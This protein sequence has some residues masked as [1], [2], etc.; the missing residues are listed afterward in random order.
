MEDERGVRVRKVQAACDVGHRPPAR[1]SENSLR[2]R[3]PRRRRRCGAWR[4]NHHQPAALPAALFVRRSVEIRAVLA[5]RG[6]TDR[7]RAIRSDCRC[8]GALRALAGAGRRRRRVNTRR[9]LHGLRLWRGYDGRPHRVHGSANRTKRCG[10]HT[11]GRLC[12]TRRD[13]CRHARSRSDRLGSRRG[14]RR[15]EQRRCRVLRRT[16]RRRRLRICGPRRARGSEQR[17]DHRARGGRHG[18]TVTLGGV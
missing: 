12:R 15:R 17:D 4:K 8:H 6:G 18:I 16:R 13:L 9:L 14:G 5:A 2:L 10:R 11:H 1:H 3:T 7:R